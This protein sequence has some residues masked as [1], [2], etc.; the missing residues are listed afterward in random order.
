MKIMQ[1]NELIK[2]KSHEWIIKNNILV[3]KNEA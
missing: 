2:A 3:K 1:Q